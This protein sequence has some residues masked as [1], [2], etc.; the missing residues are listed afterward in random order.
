VSIPCEV[1]T[2]APLTM[3]LSD[4][5]AIIVLKNAPSNKFG[6]ATQSR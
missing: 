5:H 4:L 2:V 3:V 6:G 1:I